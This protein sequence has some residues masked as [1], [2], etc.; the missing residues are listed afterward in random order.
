MHSQVRLTIKNKTSSVQL[1][2][3]PLVWQLLLIIVFGSRDVVLVVCRTI[4][5]KRCMPFMYSKTL[6]ELLYE[7]I[8][9]VV[10]LNI[11]GGGGHIKSA[12]GASF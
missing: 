5:S 11:L 6:Q 9:A 12:G 4:L 10:G 1:S 2:T 8:S 3:G 7:L